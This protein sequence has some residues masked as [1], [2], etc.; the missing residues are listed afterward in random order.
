MLL[1]NALRDSHV[2]WLLAS[3]IWL[4]L[5]CALVHAGFQPDHWQLHHT[6]SGTGPYPTGSVITFALI[7][8]EEN[9]ALGLM[10]QAWRFHRLW[11][12]MLIGIL[13]WLGWTLLWGASAMHQSPV[14]GVH[15]LWLLAACA[16]LLLALLVIEPV[17]ACPR[18]RRWLSR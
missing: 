6:D 14:R 4:L 10:V 16:I 7:I 3:L 17:S 9:V 12:R 15:M 8:A 11:L 2:F 5:V 1:P 18:L 13:P